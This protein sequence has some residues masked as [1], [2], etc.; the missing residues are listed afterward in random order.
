MEIS[1][2]LWMYF[3]NQTG[4]LWG[5]IATVDGILK[6][7]LR[8]KEEAGL[9]EAVQIILVHHKFKTYSVEL[10]RESGSDPRAGDSAEYLD[11]PL[12]P[13]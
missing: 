2:F 13:K 7:G 11:L 8:P 1:F 3:S 9:F 12:I 4:K 5:P 6:R 10:F